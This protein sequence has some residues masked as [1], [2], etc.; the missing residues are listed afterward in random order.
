MPNFKGAITSV[1]ALAAFFVPAVS[2]IFGLLLSGAASATPVT[3]YT[4]QA[5]WLEAVSPH[6]VGP[7]PQDVTRIDTLTTTGNSAAC[8][9]LFVC[10]LGQS[11]V[12]TRVGF[13]NFFANLAGAGDAFDQHC[14]Q[15]V[16]TVPCTATGLTAVEFIFDTPIFGFSALL[17]GTAAFPI[18]I[19]VTLTSGISPF[20]EILPLDGLG[21]SFFG[22][23]GPL[24]VL[25]FFSNVRLTDS[26]EI[27]SLQNIIVASV[28]EPSPAASL[29]T[30]LFIFVLVGLAVRRVPNRGRSAARRQWI[31]CT[32]GIIGW[33]S[34]ALSPRL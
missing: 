34:T 21:P 32:I 10:A 16:S 33:R 18:S 11:S 17:S 28:P 19:N 26:P 1:A 2:A 14:F 5:A 24:S 23:V 6:V 4:D 30:G 3:F 7:Y 31:F 27:V 20:P 9:G 12:T 25:D 8:G 29:A 15:D 13:T 22:V